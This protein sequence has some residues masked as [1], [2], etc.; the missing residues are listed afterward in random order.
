M[1]SGELNDSREALLALGRFVDEHA[2]TLLNA[3]GNQ[4]RRMNEAADL[5]AEQGQPN[6]ARVFRDEAATAFRTFSDLS[7]LLEAL[8]EGRQEDFANQD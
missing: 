1:A 3:L 2:A 6:Y 7:E 5:A 8:S 4:S